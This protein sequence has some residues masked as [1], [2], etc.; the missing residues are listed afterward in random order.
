MRLCLS[1]RIKWV[2][3]SLVADQGGNSPYWNLPIY[4][5]ARLD[6]SQTHDEVQNGPPSMYDDTDP[7]DR[8]K[9]KTDIRRQGPRPEPHD[10]LTRVVLPVQDTV[11]L[12]D[13]Y[14]EDVQGKSNDSTL[15]GA[16]NE[17][18][19][20]IGFDPD[21]VDQVRDYPFAEWDHA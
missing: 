1:D 13:H 11:S 18:R 8:I 6:Q 15:P 10:P 16:R 5:M 17:N 20:T 21:V 2:A 9:N 4:E 3:R 7:E 12:T 19:D 14:R